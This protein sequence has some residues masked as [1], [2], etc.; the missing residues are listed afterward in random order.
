MW[1][2]HCNI[3]WYLLWQPIIWN[4]KFTGWQSVATKTRDLDRA[5]HDSLNEYMTGLVTSIE[6][7]LRKHLFYCR[8]KMTQKRTCILPL[9][10]CFSP[11]SNMVSQ[12]VSDLLRTTKRSLAGNRDF[13]Y[14][15]K[16]L[17]LISG[18]PPLLGRR[19]RSWESEIKQ[20]RDE[21]A[22][23]KFRTIMLKNSEWGGRRSESTEGWFRAIQYGKWSCVW[24][25]F[26]NI[27]KRRKFGVMVRQST[28]L[29][30][31]QKTSHVAT[32]FGNW[33]KQ[34]HCWSSPLLSETGKC[35]NIH[36]SA[37]EISVEPRQYECRLHVHSRRFETA[38]LWVEMI[39]SLCGF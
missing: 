3:Q 6:C 34:R 16:Y 17:R 32:R 23:L 31:N 12:C 25:I 9:S 8:L 20:E 39:V 24:I 26:E 10:V 27:S 4:G 29:Q 21:S 19:F 30:K 13:R 15:Q 5:S 2:D 1:E 11:G 28:S 36:K 38:G 22:S 7:L 14:K 33:C 37:I 18:S 35:Q